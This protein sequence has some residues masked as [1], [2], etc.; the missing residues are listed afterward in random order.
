MDGVRYRQTLLE[1]GARLDA[2]GETAPIPYR[3]QNGGDY[4]IPS[5]ELKSGL[6]G[7]RQ[8]FDIHVADPQAELETKA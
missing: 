3:M 7:G 6:S 4:E 2:L 1:L 8:G 5:M